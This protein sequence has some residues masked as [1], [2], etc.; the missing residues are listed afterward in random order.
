[1]YYGHVKYIV[2]V[3]HKIEIEITDLLGYIQVPS[4]ACP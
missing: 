3:F 1:M 4:R 2:G